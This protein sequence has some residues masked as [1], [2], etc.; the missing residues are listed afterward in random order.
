MEIYKEK[1][2]KLGNSFSF[3]IELSFVHFHF[4]SLGLHINKEEIS[5]IPSMKIHKEKA[6]LLEDH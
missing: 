5:N 2:G 6:I 3:I 1:L 4:S